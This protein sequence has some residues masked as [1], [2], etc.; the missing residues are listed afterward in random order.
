M[1]ITC[2][3]IAHFH[4]NFLLFI[5]KKGP[6]NSLVVKRRASNLQDV[7]CRPKENTACPTKLGLQH[8]CARKCICFLKMIQNTACLV[9]HFPVN[10]LCIRI[11]MFYYDSIQ[12]DWL[13]YARHYNPQ[14][15]Y[16]LPHFWK[17][18]TFFQGAFLV[19]FWSY[20]RL[21]FKSGL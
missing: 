15:V 1:K 8:Y 2:H 20:V 4:G 10:S 11:H 21:V 18:K 19:K 3:K 5:W 16:I 13:P 9:K 12:I 17:P 14:F 7:F 6:P